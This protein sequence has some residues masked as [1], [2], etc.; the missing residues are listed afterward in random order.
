MLCNCL[1]AHC[2]LPKYCVIHAFRYVD[3]CN[4]Y[5]FTPLH[6]AAMTGATQAAEVLITN[7]AKLCPRSMYDSLE[8]VIYPPFTTPLHVAA[9]EG[10]IGVAK[11]VL[12]AYV[13]MLGTCIMPHCYSMLSACAVQAINRLHTLPIPVSCLV[14]LSCLIPI[15]LYLY[16]CL[17]CAYQ[18]PSVTDTLLLA[19]CCPDGTLHWQP[20]A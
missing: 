13:S 4:I 1:A 8:V 2:V 19:Y 14:P 15:P 11:V 5:G 18:I 7:G 20:H 12:Q 9:T 3:V 6:Y 10:S 17:A 16:L